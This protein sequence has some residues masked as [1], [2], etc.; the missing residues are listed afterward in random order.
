[1]PPKENLTISVSA[2]S[3]TVGEDAVIVV[4]GLKDATGNVTVTVNGK[5][6][7]ASINGDK[8][9]IVVSGLI[10]NAT[11]LISYPGD[12]KYNAASTTVDIVVN[13]KAKENATISI[14]AP[15]ITEGESATVTV[16]LPR[17][18]TG[19]VTIG[20]KVVPV[21]DGVASVVLANLPVG[22]NFL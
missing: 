16:T 21:K 8:V 5:T 1:M 18:A 4:S 7:T 6:Y 22:N 12:A 15:E 13:P 3:I 2:D 14:D 19:S 9:T 10:E 11:A 20:G 17:D